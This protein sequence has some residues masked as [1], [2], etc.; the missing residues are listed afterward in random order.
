MRMH[1]R[2]L[3][4]RANLCRLS[5]TRRPPRSKLR[6]RSLNRRNLLRILL[7]ARQQ[8]QPLMLHQQNPERP[9]LLPPHPQS[10]RLLP[11]RRAMLPPRLLPK[12]NLRPRWH[13]GRRHRMWQRQPG[14][15]PPNLKLSQSLNRSRE[16]RH[17]RKGRHRKHIR[18]RS[19]RRRN[20][21]R[22]ACLHAIEGAQNGL[23]PK[24][25]MKVNLY[26]SG[27]VPAAML[28]T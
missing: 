28:E 25:D 3:A 6:Q 20:V 5:A 22:L 1:M 9:R 8:S 15:R 19:L 4:P 21:E 14:H 11:R 23:S 16:Q 10:R 13:V 7:R 2:S 24:S 26:R 12:P 18:R 27:S 17:R